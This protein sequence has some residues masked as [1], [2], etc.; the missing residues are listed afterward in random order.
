MRIRLVG[1]K[2]MKKEKMVC[3]LT[4]APQQRKV[5]LT[6]G[7]VIASSRWGQGILLRLLIKVKMAN[8]IPTAS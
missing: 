3:R 5:M 8:S 2:E 4:A 6:F 1:W 7:N